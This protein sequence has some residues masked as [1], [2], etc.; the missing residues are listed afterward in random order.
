VVWW[1][2]SSLRSLNLA[3]NKIAPSWTSFPVGRQGTAWAPSLTGLTYL[4]V[5][6]SNVN[7][8]ARL[9]LF[10]SSLTHLDLNECTKIILLPNYYRL[11]SLLSNDYRPSLGASLKTLTRLNLSSTAV[12]DEGMRTLA[13]LTALSHLELDNT[14]VTDRGVRSLAPL[15]AHLTHPTLCGRKCGDAEL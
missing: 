1:P 2:L 12:D 6:K 4:S 11:A 8:L 14:A 9:A 15:T 3:D 5:A 7:H 10:M 13:P